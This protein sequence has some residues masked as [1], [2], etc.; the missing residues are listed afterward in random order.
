[1][2]IALRRY[3]KGARSERE[4]LNKFYELGYSVVRAAGS[5][6][7]AL[8]PDILA[9]KGE[10]CFAIECKAWDRG[11]LSIEPEQFSKLV[12]WEK[13]TTSKTFVAWKI[14]HK[15]WYFIRLDEFTKAERNYNVT[16]KKVF[17]INRIFGSVVGEQ[18]QK[19][20]E[21]VSAA[22]QQQISGPGITA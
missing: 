11:S 14:K 10:V 16:M 13:N 8:G 5:G 19:E 9:L 22:V 4:L 6:V 7:N 17:Q 1:M 15:G 20:E 12:E 2:A 21:A 3:V 18:V